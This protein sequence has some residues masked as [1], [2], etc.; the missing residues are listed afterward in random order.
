MALKYKKILK[1]F[2]AA[3]SLAGIL[4][5]LTL[6]KKSSF[7]SEYLFTRG[8]SRTYIYFVGSINSL[9]PF[10][11]F[12]ILCGIAII[13]SVIAIIRW[14]KWLK[15][16][17]YSLFLGSVARVLIVALSVGVLYTATAS[18]SYTRTPLE[19]ELPQYNDE[20]DKEELLAA[21]TYFRD[22]FNALA[23][24]FPRDAEGNAIPPYDFQGMNDAVVRSYEK[25]K[26]NPY[27][28]A[29]TPDAKKVIASPVM[30]LF[31]ITGVSFQPTGEPN[32][33]YV[34][35]KIHM[36]QLIAHEIAHS[37]GVMRENDAELL[38]AYVTLTSDDPY[39]RYSG[40]SIYFWN[41]YNMLLL[42]GMQ[43]EAT[44]IYKGLDRAIF[45]ELNNAY[46]KY[47]KYETF[48]ED[49]GTFFNDIYLKLSGVK[50]GVD[51]YRP[52]ATIIDTV[53]DEDEPV[54]I[55][56]YTSIQKLCFALYKERT[57]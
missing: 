3:V 2:I 16:K 48:I 35:P 8:I 11:V 18:F 21:V 24:S 1:L 31:G 42:N 13:L 49:I 57:E 44:E 37:K 41:I 53:D 56:Y 45:K 38:A 47:D 10:S 40:Y 29:Y 36:P 22:D 51:S 34:T 46:A 27:F 5:I 26:D 20:I 28:N 55:I 17:K 7:I 39:V 25:L 23:A 9:F 54:R 33:N 30:M 14:I 4:V 32:I 6:L 19:N 52:P 12:E 15:R 43:E 50:D